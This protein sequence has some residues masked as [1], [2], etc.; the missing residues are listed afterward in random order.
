[1]NSKISF[2]NSLLIL[3]QGGLWQVPS[4]QAI[5]EILLESGARVTCLEIDTGHMGLNTTFTLPTKVPTASFHSRQIPFIPNTIAGLLQTFRYLRREFR[6]NGLPKLVLSTGP[7]EQVLAYGLKLFLGVPYAAQVHEI[8]DRSERGLLARFFLKLEGACLRHADF[9]IMPDQGRIDLYR[10]RYQLTQEIFLVMNTPRLRK[11]LSKN[12]SLR[13]RLGLPRQAKIICYV[14]GMSDDNGLSLAVQMLAH[15]PHLALVAIGWSNPGYRSEV[16]ALAKKLGVAD[17]VRLLPPQSDKWEWIDNAD[18]G[19]SVYL[20]SGG[21]RFRYLGTSSNKLFEFQSAGVPVVVHE[22]SDQ[23]PWVS[24][25]A[26]GIGVGHDPK[27][28]A[29]QITKLLADKK[30]YRELSASSRADHLDS[31]N[32]EVQFTAAKNRILQCLGVSLPSKSIRAKKNRGDTQSP[33]LKILNKR[34]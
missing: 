19:L 25:Y 14:G 5:G 26:W 9:L 34:N 31:F 2:E 17:R 16:E 27:H 4:T 3:R 23:M 20:L 21:I 8:Q 28:W 1:M 32:Y 6:E 29:E 22:T 18:L 7:F 13:A 12:I 10:E 30:R 11:H 24:K 15:A 33:R